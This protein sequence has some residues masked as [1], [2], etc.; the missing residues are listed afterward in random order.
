MKGNIKAL[1]KDYSKLEDKYKK[2]GEEREEL[3]GTIVAELGKEGIDKTE[4]TFGIF[5]IGKRLTYKYSEK[6]EAL[7]DKVKLAKVREE[8][9]GIAKA[10]ETR[11]LVFTKPAQD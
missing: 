9:K 4:T 2:M 6:V 8:E 10:S 1:L 5:T 11:Y 7:Q 3:R